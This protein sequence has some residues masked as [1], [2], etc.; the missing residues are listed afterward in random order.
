MR[1]HRVTTSLLGALALLLAA[2]G[3][4]T[5]ESPPAGQEVDEAA[6][7]A[8]NEEDADDVEDGDAPADLDEFLDQAIAAA[9]A[10]RGVAEEEIE[11]LRAEEV[12]WPDG[13]RGCPEEGEM[14]T[15][16]IVPGYLAVLDVAGEEQYWHGAEGEAPFHCEDPQAPTAD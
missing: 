14:Y 12:E 10:E 11:V 15:Q 8:E 3:G 7:D 1:Q 16:A 13:A 2:C 5:D 9:V 4:A 6:P